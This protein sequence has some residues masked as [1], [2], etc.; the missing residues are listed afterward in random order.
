M[1]DW[2]RVS[3]SSSSPTRCLGSYVCMVD[4]RTGG[5]AD[6]W[7]SNVCAAGS[8]RSVYLRI[9]DSY[10]SWMFRMFCDLISSLTLFSDALSSGRSL[11]GYATSCCIWS[12][13][14]FMF[15]RT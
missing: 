9:M 1:L 7:L 14:K 3:S 13:V 8:G 6:C 5:T 15:L 2:L 10:G 12:S 11:Y 4:V